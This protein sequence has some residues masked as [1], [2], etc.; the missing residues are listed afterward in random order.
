MV[1]HSRK[2]CTSRKR[3]GRP[4]RRVL[5]HTSL[6]HASG[7]VDRLIR[8]QRRRGNFGTAFL[9]PDP[10]AG[11]GR[12]PVHG[13]LS[14]REGRLCP[15]LLPHPISD[16]PDIA[17]R[18]DRYPSPV[19]NAQG[20]SQA[21]KLAS[22]AR[23]S[24]QP[25]SVSRGG[26]RVGRPGARERKRLCWLRPQALHHTVIGGSINRRW[27]GAFRNVIAPLPARELSS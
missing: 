10:P 17:V 8:G 16:R 24:A 14:R 23:Q 12:N 13:L 21:V 15:H 3:C 4:V 27:H 19:K 2:A 26:V 1:S 7:S 9:Q 20:P 25:L 5:P 22:R 18:T 11:H 6:V